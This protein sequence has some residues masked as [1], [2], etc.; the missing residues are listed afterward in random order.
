ME[1]TVVEDSGFRQH[2]VLAMPSSGCDPRKV[3]LLS[4]SGSVI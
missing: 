1:L 2:Q 3:C 4:T